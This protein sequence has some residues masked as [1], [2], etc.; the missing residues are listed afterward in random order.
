M[1]RRAVGALVW[2]AALTNNGAMQHPNPK[3]EIA[4]LLVQSAVPTLGDVGS[5]LP[6]GLGVVQ[7]GGTL[8]GFVADQLRCL[9]QCGAPALA[10][11]LI[12]DTVGM[13]SIDG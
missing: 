9:A 11:G 5:D 12:R 1:R 13:V 7:L 8:L 10:L 3:A 6:S 2:V 4:G